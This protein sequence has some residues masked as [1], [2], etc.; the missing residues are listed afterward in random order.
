MKEEYKKL[1][2]TVGCWY[3]VIFALIFV[4][5]IYQC[6]LGSGDLLL[7]FGILWW[8]AIPIVFA[9]IFAPALIAL[10]FIYKKTI[11]IN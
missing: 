4:Y 1:L 3:L 5:V 7:L 9:I 11:N 10:W 2:K 8:V 6:I